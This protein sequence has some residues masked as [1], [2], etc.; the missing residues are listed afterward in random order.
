MISRPLAS[1]ISVQSSTSR[2][3]CSENEDCG[4]KHQDETTI[5]ISQHQYYCLRSSK[6]FDAKDKIVFTVC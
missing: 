5:K 1:T 3:T 4:K 6:L 2:G